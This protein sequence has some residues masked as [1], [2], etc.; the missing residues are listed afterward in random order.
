M[1]TPESFSCLLLLFLYSHSLLE[2]AEEEAEEAEEEEEE[3][4]SPRLCF[5]PHRVTSSLHCLPPL[6]TNHNLFLVDIY[7]TVLVLL[8]LHIC[9]LFKQI[10]SSKKVVDTLTMGAVACKNTRGVGRVVTVTVIDSLLQP[11]WAV[12]LHLLVEPGLLDIVLL[13]LVCICVFM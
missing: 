6:S 9:F 12:H 3:G 1:T 5:Q 7:K 10:K 2:E 8:A 4:G 13:L 11:A